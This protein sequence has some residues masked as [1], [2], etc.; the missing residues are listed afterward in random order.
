MAELDIYNSKKEPKEKVKIKEDFFKVKIKG[1][2]LHQVVDATLWNKRAG[3]AHT[4]ER[5]EVRGGGAKPYK[6]KGTGQARRGTSRS[7]LIRGGGT[8]FGPR[9]REYY[10]KVNDKVKKKALYYSL[11]SKVQEK[12]LIIIDEIQLEKPRTA[13]VK[14]ILNTFAVKSALIVDKENENLKLSARNI[15]NIKY[16]ES[17]N[18]NVYDLLKYEK[19]IVTKNSLKE[20]FK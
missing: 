14:K 6:Q 20:V 7:P 16:R 10:K 15:P 2:I 11:A 17:K 12:N 9:T 1:H 8:T 18:L 13:N 4:K 19:L 3:T 5:A